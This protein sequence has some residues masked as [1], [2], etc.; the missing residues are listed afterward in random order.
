MGKI[1]EIH[2]T[3]ACD[4]LIIGAGGAGLRC[5]ALIHERRPDLRITAVTKVA[6]PQ[7]SHTSTA[8]GGLAA[9]DP[10]DRR[11]KSI[12]HMFDT[13]KGGD[14]S[15]DQ[16]VVKKIVDGGWGEVQWM[17]RRGIHFSRDEEGNI[18]KRQFGGHTVEF[19][20]GDALRAVFEADRTGKGIMDTAWG[21]A[22]KGGALFIN[23]TVVTELLFNEGCCVGA[24]LFKAKEGE[25][26]AVTARAT[27][28]ATGGSGQVFR[29]TTNCRNN[30]GDGLAVILRAGLPLM[31][32]EAV[33]F[34]PTGIVGPGILASEALRSEGGILRN[35]DLEPFM[36]RYAPKMKDLAPRDIVAR[37]IETEIREGR[38]I[39]NP[40]HQ[41]EHVWIDLR[42]L[43]DYV[44]EV[45][46]KEV[47]SF[48]K[49]YVNLDS[50]T[51]LCPVRPS[52][53][54]HMGGI[55]TNEHGEVQK[56]VGE[57][58]PGLFAVGE[59][60]CASFH[61]FNRLGTNSLLELLVMGRYTGER[62][63]SYLEEKRTPP[64]KGGG[65]ATL[66]LFSGYLGAQGKENAALIRQEMRELMTR[67]VGVFRTEKGILEAIASLID[68]K[69]R[70]AKVAIS[71]KE[72]KMNQELLERWELD[73]LLD[74]AMTIAQGA[75]MRKESRGA[76]FREDYP[77][78]NDDFQFHTLV[79]MEEFGKVR[80]GKRPI[81]MSLYENQG[82]HFERFKTIPRTY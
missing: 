10:K 45:K 80:F 23:S 22:L 67:N 71:T 16:N 56:T 44:H 52:N 7:K 50:R 74:N 20:Q 30:T 41:I 51:Q 42:H 55:P 40:D 43:P 14:C 61:G 77:D 34:H 70:A 1:L 2:S 35:K 58:V 64:P 12:Y 39:M 11:D 37:S 78:R 8:Q 5:A 21:E 62:V 17:E 63:L 46:L 82:D 54:Y 29:I 27:V 73:N 36:E 69:Q 33:Q 15:S 59:C 4:V 24:L 66:A 6:H 25:L 76:H 68:F 9:V 3:L 79:S 38:G 32:P 57:I 19:G 60:A 13:W 48:F 26:I 18:S 75:L 31:D 81:D 49:T 65:E 28:L 53:H 47:A 72:L